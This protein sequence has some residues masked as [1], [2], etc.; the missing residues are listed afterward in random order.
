[1]RLLLFLRPNIDV[2]NKNQLPKPLLA[3]LYYGLHY[4]SSSFH[5]K[6][7]LKFAY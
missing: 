6:F 1:M 3:A 5:K 7:T 2:D 4:F